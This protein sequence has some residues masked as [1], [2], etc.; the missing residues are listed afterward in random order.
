MKNRIFGYLD[1]PSNYL[2]VS[3][4][5]T[6]LGNLRLWQIP[7]SDEELDIVINEIGHSI[8]P[9]VY[10]LFGEKGEKKVHIG[11]SE[12]LKA[13]MSNNISYP[14]EKIKNWERAIIISDA[15]NAMQ[16]DLNDE[17][18]RHILANYLINLFKI[19]RYKVMTTS[20]RIPSL[21]STQIILA[22]FFK[23]ELNLLLIRKRLIT[24]VL[25]DNIKS[26][27]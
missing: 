3:S 8:L 26:S 16:S 19:N 14:D 4:S 11:Q 18:I 21:H 13:R 1:N 17:I 6:L 2:G 25:T 5:R 10:L 22:N 15:R 23:E 7:R 20:S 27:I 24:K 9:G 12:N